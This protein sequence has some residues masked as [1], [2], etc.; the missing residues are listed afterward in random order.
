M[1]IPVKAVC[2]VA[3]VWPLGRMVGTWNELSLYST[4]E[5]LEE[6]STAI[7]PDG[8]GGSGGHSDDPANFKSVLAFAFLILSKKA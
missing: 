2:S 4:S 7:V 8:H 6:E 1:P 3:E 5:N